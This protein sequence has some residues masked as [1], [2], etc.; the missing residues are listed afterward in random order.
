MAD[1]LDTQQIQ[2]SISRLLGEVA[3]HLAFFLETILPSLVEG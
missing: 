3:K 2:T 1:Q